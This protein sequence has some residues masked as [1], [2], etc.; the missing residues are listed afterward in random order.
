MLFGHRHDLEDLAIGLD[1]NLTIGFTRS[2]KRELAKETE[3]FSRFLLGME[4]L[5]LI[6]EYRF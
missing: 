6:V 4:I 1:L 2:K 3:R 5:P